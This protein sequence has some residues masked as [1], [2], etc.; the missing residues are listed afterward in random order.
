METVYFGNNTKSDFPV[1]R[2][3][4][5]FL[6]HENLYKIQGKIDIRSLI[7]STEKG[8]FIQAKTLEGIPN[9]SYCLIE[10]TTKAVE[11]L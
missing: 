9:L 2:D 10:G 11:V 4:P 8:V 3:T 7:C 5:V 6:S 1:Y